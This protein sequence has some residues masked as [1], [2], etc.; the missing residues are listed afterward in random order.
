MARS[1]ERER[2]E[3]REEGRWE[4]VGTSSEEGEISLMMRYTIRRRLGSF[5]W[6]SFVTA[7]NT[8]VASVC[9]R[10]AIQGRYVRDTRQRGRWEEREDG[11]RLAGD[12]TG[13]E[14][15]LEREGRLGGAS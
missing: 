10:E 3:R 14:E 9:D 4:G 2:E 11:E 6:K 1:L 7:K 5:D 13:G 15:G 12:G 8:S